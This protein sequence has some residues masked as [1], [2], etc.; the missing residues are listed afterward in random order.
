MLINAGLDD[1]SSLKRITFKFCLILIGE[2]I[3]IEK[4]SFEI[5]NFL[6]H[7]DN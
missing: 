4:C 7:L 2:K 6:C 3:A 1:L 5:L